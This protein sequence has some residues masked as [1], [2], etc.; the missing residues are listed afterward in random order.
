MTDVTPTWANP[1]TATSNNAP[2]NNERFKVAKLKSDSIHYVRLAIH[3]SQLAVA[4][5]LLD[6]IAADTRDQ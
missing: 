5:Y 2:E 4:D 6:L 3:D 1:P